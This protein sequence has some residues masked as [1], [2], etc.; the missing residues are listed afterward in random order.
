M[1][2]ESILPEDEIPKLSFSNYII[3]MLKQDE[4]SIA[5]IET[6]SDTKFTCS[7]VIEKV[8]KLASALT[9]KGLKKQEI[10]AVCI[11][12]SIYYPIITLA[13][14]ACNAI[15][16]PC[17]P[18]YT[19]SELVKQFKLCRPSFIITDFNQMDKIK[20]VVNQIK[21]VKEMFTL[22]KKHSLCKTTIVDMIKNDNGADYNENIEVNPEEDVAMLPYS[23]GTTGLPKGVMLTHKNCVTLNHICQIG[24]PETGVHCH[25]LP[26]FHA[27]GLLY[28]FLLIGEM[29][30]VI[31]NRFR[32]REFFQVVEKYKITSLGGV[33]SVLTELSKSPL[34]N[35]YDLSSLKFVGSGAA[36]LSPEVQRNTEEKMNVQVSQGWGLTECTV[37]ATSKI[38]GCPT[39]SVGL[40]M[41]HTKLKVVDPETNEELG[42]NKKGEICVTGP[43]VMKGY[44]ENPEKNLEAFDE[45]GWFKTGDIGYYT[46]EGFI[47]LLDRLKE[48]IKYKGFQVRFSWK[49]NQKHLDHHD[50][51]AGTSG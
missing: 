32:I 38:P 29:P 20:K 24:P 33:P 19:E 3:E 50:I 36:A 25:V 16:S 41:P 51:Y 28:M 18:N 34:V 37:I 49:E 12:N 48:L 46:D 35:E 17:N 8:K 15:M 40:L 4:S 11:G 44:F 10:I 39:G 21:S 26:L 1:V 43:Q 30:F 5:Y 22:K 27:Y 6:T 45:H 9:K 13:I 47:Y 31:M 42:P 23:S 14:N 2:L 7:E